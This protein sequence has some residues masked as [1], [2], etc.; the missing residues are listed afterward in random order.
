MDMFKPVSSVLQKLAADSSSGTHRTDGD[1][2]FKHLT[3]FEFVFI[4]CMMREILEITELLGQA[5]QKKRQ[6]IVNAIHLVQSTKV[7]LEQLR[8]DEGWEHFFNMVVEFCITHDI[9]IPDMEEPY[10][11]RGGRAR[12]QPDHFTKER[13]FR[14]EIFRATI[15]TQLTELN[16][17]FNEK[18]LGLLSISVTLV[19]KHGFASF[20][21][22]E[23]CRMVEKYYPADFIKRELASLERQL[24]HFVVHVSQSEDLKNI[25]TIG[26]LC[27]RLVITGRDKTFTL[28]DR[29][30]RLLLTLPVSTATAERVFSIL[31]ITKTRLRNKM[32]DEFLANSLLIHIEGDVVEHYTLLTVKIRQPSHEFTFGVGMSFIPY[33]LV[34]TPVV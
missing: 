29:L 17:K 6:D 23:I 7:L 21:A 10:I 8:S 16:L 3:S 33:P 19:P 34:L 2:S 26:D 30:L 4:L 25:G 12:R 15:D 11:M 27:R 32:E 28:I 22:T 9:D 13:Y 1:T 5:L 31:K 14:V 24:K 18:V 20:K